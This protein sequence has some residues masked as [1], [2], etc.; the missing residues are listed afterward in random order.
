MTRFRALI[1][2]ALALLGLAACRPP[3]PWRCCGGIAGQFVH[4]LI[5]RMTA[6]SFDPL[7]CDPMRFAQLQQF[8]PKVGVFCGLGR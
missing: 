4:K 2:P 5:F 3:L 6:V 1:L 7:K 8:F